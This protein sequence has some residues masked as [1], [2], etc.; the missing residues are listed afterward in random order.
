MNQAIKQEYKNPF[1]IDY[2][3]IDCFN[4]KIKENSKLT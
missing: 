1:K 2:E 4:Y 3:N